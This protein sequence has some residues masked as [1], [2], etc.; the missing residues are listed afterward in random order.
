VTG[1]VT[2]LRKCQH[3]ARAD[4]RPLSAALDTLDDR[5]LARLAESLVGWWPRLEA[6]RLR[7]IAALDERQAYRVDGARDTASWLAW[8]AGDRRGSARREVELAAAVAAMPAVEAGLAEGSLSKAKAAELGRVSQA[9]ADEQE[10]LVEAAKALPVEAV[11]REVDRWQLDHRPDR[12]EIVASVQLTPTRSGG[13][14]DATLDAEGFEW[15]QLAIDTAAEHLACPICPGRNAAPG[16][17]SECAATS[18]TTPTCPSAGKDGPRSSSPSTSRRSPRPA[19]A[20]RGWT[21]GPTCRVMSPAGWPATLG[22]S[23]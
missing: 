7:V 9:A 10:R 5:S 13:R 23:D 18:S 1:F 14:L 16:A 15:A 12:V 2:L 17:S 22:S 6:A 20:V 11:A 21:P 8:K 3:A 19:V 4:R